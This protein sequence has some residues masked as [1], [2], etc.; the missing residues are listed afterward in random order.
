MNMTETTITVG[1]KQISF[2][3]PQTPIDPPTTYPDVGDTPDRDPYDPVFD[4]TVGPAPI[5]SP[6]AAVLS[7]TIDDRMVEVDEATARKIAHD[8]L[9][10]IGDPT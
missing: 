10:R 9:N 2:L 8:I 3:H 1:G 4:L 7:F 5:G 6:P